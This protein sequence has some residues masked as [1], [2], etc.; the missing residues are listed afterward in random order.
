MTLNSTLYNS[1]IFKTT[2]SFCNVASAFLSHSYTSLKTDY[3]IQEYTYVVTV[4]EG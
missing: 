1:F 4:F 3:Y 2:L